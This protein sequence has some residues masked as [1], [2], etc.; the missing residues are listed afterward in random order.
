MCAVYRRV[1]KAGELHR[2]H[3][4]RL[5]IVAI[6]MGSDE[7]VVREFVEDIG[8]SFLVVLDSDLA[9][10]KHFDVSKLPAII[11]IEFCRPVGRHSLPRDILRHL[12]SP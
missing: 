5:T 12:E 7:A 8:I 3:G 9:V 4:D 2:T 1:S 11:A 10:S 6:D